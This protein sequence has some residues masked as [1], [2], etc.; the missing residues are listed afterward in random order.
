MKLQKYQIITCLLVLY[1]S[2][3]TI[4]FG[5][6]LLKDGHSV[7]FWVTLIAEVIV[8]ILAFFALRRRDQYRTRRKK[9]LKDL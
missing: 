2:F 7:R 1:A 6:D 9:E 4:Y 5:M 3:M 8:I